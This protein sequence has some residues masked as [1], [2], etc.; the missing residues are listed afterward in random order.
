MAF[1]IRSN[2][3][4]DQEFHKKEKSAEPVK[5]CPQIADLYENIAAA[6]EVVPG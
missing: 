3:L 1:D 2:N 5:T 4:G 6:G